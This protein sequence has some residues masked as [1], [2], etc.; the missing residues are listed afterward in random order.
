MRFPGIL[1][2]LLI[3]VLVWSAIDPAERLTWWL[4]SLPVLIAVPLLMATAARFP[5]T[6]LAYGLIWLHCVILLVGAHYNYAHVPAGNWLRDA[7]DLSRNHYDRLGHFVQGAIPAIV[8]RELLIRLTPIR[9]DKWLFAI[10][11][12]S[13]LGVSAAYE[14]LE[15]LAA[16]VAGADADSFLGHQGDVWDAQKDM[17]LALTGAMLAQLFLGRLHDRQIMTLAR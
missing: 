3:S 5:L 14:L 8:A 11:T 17:A 6:P 7:F 13:M 2:G 9:P 12:L 4:E 1:L 15:W 10:V 16:V